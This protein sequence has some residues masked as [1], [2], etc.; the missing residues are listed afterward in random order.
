MKVFIADN[1]S[2][3]DINEFQ[4]E[5][6]KEINSEIEN[7]EKKKLTVEQKRVLKNM[8]LNPPPDKEGVRYL[9]TREV[10][11]K[12]ELEKAKKKINQIMYFIKSLVSKERNLHLEIG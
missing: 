5:N 9:A 6:E 7:I 11:F 1:V 12:K 3:L 2:S 10:F 4:K 8:G